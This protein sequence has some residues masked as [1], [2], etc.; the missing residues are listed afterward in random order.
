MT[1]FGSQ[2]H[3]VAVMKGILLS[4]CPGI[5]IV[6]LTHKVPPQNV[7]WAAFQLLAGYR[8][9]QQDTLFLCVVDPGVGTERRVIYVEAGKWR[10]IAPDNGLLS[11]VLDHEK[12]TAIVDI[13]AF[14]K[15]HSVSRTFH[16]RDVMAPV[17][18]KILQGENPFK[19]G[20]TIDTY[21][22]ISFPEVKKYGATWMGEVL[23]IDRF[24]NLI[25]NFSCAEIKPLA[26]SSRV[27]FELPNVQETIRGLSDSYSSVPLG[28]FLAIEG[29]SGFVEISVREGNAAV[30]SGLEEGA[31][32]TLHFRT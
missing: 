10:F 18:A 11:W 21:E 19:L 9:F 30:K 25:T 29:S 6:D 32:I 12:P 23:L 24:G 15:E 3:Y 16:G 26:N 4:S 22:K 5:Q 20:P 1:D 17:A 13:S 7:K 27:W 28:R 8:Y 2:D 14:A 31:G